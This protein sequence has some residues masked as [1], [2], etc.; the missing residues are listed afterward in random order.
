ME[1]SY[2]T[3]HNHLK[4]MSETQLDILVIGGGITGAGIAL[5]GITRGLGVGVVE[6]NDFAS[7]TSSRS[8]K[9]IHGG[10]RY[11]LQGQVKTVIDVGQE[12][13]RLHENAPHLTK[14][15]KLMMPFYEDGVFNP[16]TARMAL[17]AYETLA[18]VKGNERKTMLTPR[19]SLRR[20]PALVSENL[21]GSSV[22]IEYRTD[23]SRL[24]ID[25]LKRAAEFGAYIANYTKV[26]KLLY[27]KK[28]G[29]VIGARIKDLISGE[30][31]AIYARR[32]INAT[33]PWVDKIRHLDDPTLQEDEL[34]LTKGVHLIIDR[35]RLPLNNSLYFNSPFDDGRMLFAIIR[36]DKFYIGTTDT[37]YK[38]DPQQVTP[39]QEDLT[40]L[41]EAV[42]ASFEIDPLTLADVEAAWAGLRPLI[43]QKDKEPSEISRKDEIFKSPSGLYSIGGGKL[44]GYRKMAEK[45]VNV[46]LRD[47]C[48]EYNRL[49]IRCRTETLTLSGGNVGGSH[50]FKRYLNEFV[51][52]GVD[53]FHLS[54]QVA[55]FL[56]RRYGSNV[57]DLYAI[58]LNLP[59]NSQ[60]SDLDYIMLRYGLEE[61]M[62]LH[63]LDFLRRRSNY[64][65]FDMK[66]C[67]LI[68]DPVIDEMAN[69]FQWSAE[70][71]GQVTK[72][73][74]DEI[75]T[76]LN[77][78]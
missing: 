12:R 56:V 35:K 23:D 32:V 77:F 36:Q 29:K 17:T 60:L 44:T 48:R 42:N 24:T 55:N 28:T 18:Q 15:F 76:Y 75:Q 69:F 21:T 1:F 73:T 16:L 25:V 31:K 64:L 66:H 68:K 13:H 26:V 47:I 2:K 53:K 9:L 59:V 38:G 34:L 39:S 50:G 51:A 40:Y 5:D 19:E 43:K 46:V 33:G 63:P 20:E 6:M 8:T 71:K 61:E 7:G 4:K 65:P 54:H 72:E 37:I 78:N 70:Y 49:F 14:P 52:I 74:N 41:L 58:L 11:L 57:I 22:Y 62:C 3:R 27:S 30:E 10:L 67:L 45:V